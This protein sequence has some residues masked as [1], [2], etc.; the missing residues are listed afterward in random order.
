MQEDKY[1]QAT[2]G[3][4]A[5][6]LMICCSFLCGEWSKSIKQVYSLIHSAGHHLFVRVRRLP[7]VGHV[8]VDK[9]S[10][11]LVQLTSQAGGH[12]AQGCFTRAAHQG[13][14]GSDSQL[15]VKVRVLV[16]VP[17][18]GALGE[19]GGGI[20]GNKVLLSIYVVRLVEKHFM[21]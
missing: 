21:A 15:R 1:A 20:E 10:H 7:Q 19:R 5:Y 8:T 4:V 14:V 17:Q 9:S 11:L 18:L 16:S 13:Q 2:Q 12:L 6:P 3:T